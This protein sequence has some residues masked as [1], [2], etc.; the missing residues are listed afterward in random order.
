L[1]SL[2]IKVLETKSS[3]KSRGRHSFKPCYPNDFN[4][5]WVICKVKNHLARCTFWW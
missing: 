2:E 3:C 4:S 1:A 5:L